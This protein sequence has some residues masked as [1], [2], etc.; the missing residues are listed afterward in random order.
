[1]SI[2]TLMY[3]TISNHGGSGTHIAI[4]DPKI[5]DA[6][7]SRNRN[8]TDAQPMRIPEDV[9]TVVLQT[10]HL[11]YLVLVLARYLCFMIGSPG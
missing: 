1:M 2:A 5:C 6:Q 10:L 3:S 4:S 7:F 11:S 9:Y 8:D